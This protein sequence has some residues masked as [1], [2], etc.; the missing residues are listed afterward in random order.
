MIVPTGMPDSQS[1][2]L[3]QK[4]LENRIKTKEILPVRFALMETAG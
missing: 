2:L 4:T 1:L 3:V